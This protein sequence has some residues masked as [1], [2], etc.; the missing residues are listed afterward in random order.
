MPLPENRR[1]P[2]DPATGHDDF[3]WALSAILTFAVNWRLLVPT[4]SVVMQDPE[5]HR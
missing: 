4:Q 3:G 1:D 2:P 5:I